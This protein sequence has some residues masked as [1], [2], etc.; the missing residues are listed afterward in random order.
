M[1]SNSTDNPIHSFYDPST[2]QVVLLQSILQKESRVA[3]SLGEAK[4]IGL[5]LLSLYEC[6]ARDR[7]PAVEAQDNA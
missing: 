5:E 1:N 7:T 4:E 2:E 3:V 6:L